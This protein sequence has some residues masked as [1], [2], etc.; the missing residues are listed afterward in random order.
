MGSEAVSRPCGILYIILTICTGSA[1]GLP[2]VQ[3]GRKF[4]QYSGRCLAISRPPQH[5]ELLFVNTVSEPLTEVTMPLCDGKQAC[6]CDIF[7]SGYEPNLWWKFKTRNFA[8]ESS[9]NPVTSH[10]ILFQSWARSKTHS[11][12]TAACYQ[13]AVGSNKCLYGKSE[14][15]NTAWAPL[16]W[17]TILCGWQGLT[18]NACCHDSVT[19]SPLKEE[20][21]QR[22]G[23]GREEKKRKK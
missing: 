13:G 2:S 11:L 15:I 6:T 3:S 5:K 10:L 12:D 21:E 17:V 22:V 4:L 23:G 16:W 18:H 1:W 19:Y 8:T 20:K 9:A 7:C 14:S